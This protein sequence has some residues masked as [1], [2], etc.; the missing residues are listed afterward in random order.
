MRTTSRPLFPG[1]DNGKL[2][3]EADITVK[4]VGA[5]SLSMAKHC[6]GKRH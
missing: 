2:K 4:K 3:S 1:L 6:H 5:A